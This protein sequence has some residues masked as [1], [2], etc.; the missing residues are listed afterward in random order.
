MRRR[1]HSTHEGLK[2]TERQRKHAYDEEDTC[3]T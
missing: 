1:I 2:L 3:N